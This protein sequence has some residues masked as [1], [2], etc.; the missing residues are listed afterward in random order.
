MGS[1]LHVAVW[2][3]SLLTACSMRAAHVAQASPVVDVVFL[4]LELTG[5]RPTYLD[6]RGTPS[7]GDW[8][9]CRPWISDG[10][11][12]FQAGL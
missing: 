4:N 11:H 8:A 3:P 10:A 6:P 5:T 2:L 12:C 9:I 1:W 7:G